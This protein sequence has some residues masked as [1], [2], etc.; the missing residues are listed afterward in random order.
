[1]ITDKTL[2]M[3]IGIIKQSVPNVI[4]VYQFGS[5]NTPYQNAESDLDLAL[6]AKKELS[7]LER[8]KLSQ[9]IAG[10]THRDIDII[11]LKG[12]S[13]V[14]KFQ[15]IST[16]QRIFCADT[17]TCEAFEDLAYSRYLH[18]NEERQEIIQEIVNRGKVY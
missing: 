6:L 2:Q 14:L 10:A 4:A 8:W 9:S 5:F 7:N 16:G 12:A 1:M 3:S 18:F 13:T 15:I 11:D 17:K